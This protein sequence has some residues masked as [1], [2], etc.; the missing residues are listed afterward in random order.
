M[1]LVAS[2]SMW[3][4][5]TSG[6]EPVSPAFVGGF[7]TTEPPGKPHMPFKIVNWEIDA[8]VIKMYNKPEG[9]ETRVPQCSSQHCL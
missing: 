1:G 9:K 5:P 8:S 6:M 3:D 7:F 2:H 4:L